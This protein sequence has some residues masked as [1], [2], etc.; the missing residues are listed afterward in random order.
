[1][2]KIGDGTST[3]LWDDWWCG[4]GPLRDHPDARRIRTLSSHRT[5]MVHHIIKEGA[6]DFN[7]LNLPDSIM[8]IIR[9][10][11][12]HG[13]NRDRPVWVPLNLLDP[14]SKVIYH[15][16]RTRGQDGPWRK[17]IWFKSHVPKFSFITWLAA[18]NRLPTFDRLRS[19][20]IQVDDKCLLC[21]NAQETRDH[22]FFACNFSRQILS[23]GFRKT[24]TSLPSGNLTWD[25]VLTWLTTHG[26]GSSFRKT[27]L[28]LFWTCGVHKIWRE[29]NSR[30]HLCN[31]QNWERVLILIQHDISALCS[32]FKGIKRNGLNWDICN[33]WRINLNILEDN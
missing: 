2:Y 14:S 8:D 29:R 32:K 12:L 5:C 9:M 28:K 19:W 15:E 26:S 27:I 11:P 16:I 3:H 33:N 17:L 10:T 13:G 23:E 21:Q 4:L 6:W 30:K 22:L 24:C 25:S 1:M 20:N 31:P 7:N 18:L